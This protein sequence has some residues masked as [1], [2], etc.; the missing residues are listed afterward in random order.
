VGAQAPRGLGAEGLDA[1]FPDDPEAHEARRNALAERS[2][3]PPTPAAFDRVPLAERPTEPP[4]PLADRPTLPPF[5]VPI[6]ERHTQPPT[7]RRGRTTIPISPLRLPSKPT[8]PLDLPLGLD[9]RLDIEA[10]MAEVER[11]QA[12]ST[13]PPVGED[14]AALYGRASRQPIVLHT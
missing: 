6:S 2:T 8:Q 12:R 10:M 5:A 1:I 3:L 9:G 13:P 11:G 14:V 7:R 4:V